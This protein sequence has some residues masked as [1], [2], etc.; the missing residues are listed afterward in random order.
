MSTESLKPPIGVE[1]TSVRSLLGAYVALTKP[2]IIE[3][4][5][6]NKNLHFTNCIEKQ[7]NRRLYDVHLTVCYMQFGEEQLQQLLCSICSRNTYVFPIG[8]DVNSSAKTG[9]AMGSS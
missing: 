4:L 8:T 5:L 6:I 7:G 3:L 9:T 1:Q 2:R